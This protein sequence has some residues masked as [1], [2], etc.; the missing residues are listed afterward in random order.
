M[1]TTATSRNGNP[2]ARHG[3]G[4]A[5]ED[6]AA[7][8]LERQGCRVVARR[9]GRRGGEIDLVV[10]DGGVLAFVEVRA[11]RSERYGAPIATVTARKRRRIIGTARKFL[12]ERG[13]RGRRCRFDV[14][15][16]QLRDGSARVQWVCDAF[17][18]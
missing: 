6:L 16:V 4:R 17:R 3:T 5:A 10:D 12:A 1:K 9:Y 8:Y 13:W 7:R 2:R 18:G 11:R 15:A 14:V